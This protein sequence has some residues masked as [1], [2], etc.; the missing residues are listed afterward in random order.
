MPQVFR[1]TKTGP[2]ERFLLHRRG[3]PGP[4][5]SGDLLTL[6]AA[7]GRSV[8]AAQQG[9][10]D[11]RADAERPGRWETFRVLSVPAR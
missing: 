10:G 7:R 4:I 2:W 1:R 3:G 9:E 11:P 6:Q 8:S 5:R